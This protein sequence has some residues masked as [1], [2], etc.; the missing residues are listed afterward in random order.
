VTT[1]H[2]YLQTQSINFQKHSL[3]SAKVIANMITMINHQFAQNYSLMKSIKEFGDKGCQATHE[4][5]KQLHNYI[6]FKPIGMK[7][8]STIAKRRAIES[9]IFLIEKKDRKIKA[10]T[11]AN[12]STQQEYTDQEE[13]ASTM[14]KSHLIIAVIDAKQGRDVMTTNIPNALVQMN[15]E[16]SQMV[17]KSS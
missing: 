13:A 17:R 7:K 12:G 9:L 2:G 8:P 14:T 10:R 16:K 11:C 4:V 5:T 6:I 15:I 1:H 3:D